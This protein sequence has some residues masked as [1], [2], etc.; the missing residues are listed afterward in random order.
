MSAMVHRQG[1]RDV[2][3]QGRIA[4]VSG[5]GRGIGRAIALGLAADGADVAVNYRRDEAAARATVDE[6]TK[7]GRRA[8]AYGGDV[9]DFVTCT[10]VV[11]RAVAELGPI[12]ILVA[13]GDGPPAGEGRDGRLR[14]PHHLSRNAGGLCASPRLT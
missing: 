9:G 10:S 1:E 3:L 14:H 2:R 11:E 5:G 8:A 6:I 13:N 4:L 7:L 12:D